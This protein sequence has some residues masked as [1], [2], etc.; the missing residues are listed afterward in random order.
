MKC[1]FHIYL[2]IIR[3]IS[4]EKPPQWWRHLHVVIFVYFVVRDKPVLY[5]HWYSLPKFGLTDVWK[6]SVKQKGEKFQQNFP[7]K[8]Q[9]SGHKWTLEEK[10]I[11]RSIER[12]NKLRKPS[13]VEVRLSEIQILIRHLWDRWDESCR[14]VCKCGLVRH[15]RYVYM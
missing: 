11:D 7:E 2:W 8:Y 12:Q 9:F 3:A 5:Q 13:E 6:S 10:E 1:I 15:L 14:L 4:M